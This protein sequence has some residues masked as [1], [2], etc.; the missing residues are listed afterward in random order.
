[1]NATTPPSP[2]PPAPPPSFAEAYW[3]IHQKARTAQA[4]LALAPS[5][6]GR[7]ISEQRRLAGEALLKG[8]GLFPVAYSN[9]LSKLSLFSIANYA[10]FGPRFYDRPMTTQVTALVIISI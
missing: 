9:Q 4:F 7:G 10:S 2:Q 5:H 3:H 1:M 6:Q 8:V